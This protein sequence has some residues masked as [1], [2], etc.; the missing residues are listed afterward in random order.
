MDAVNGAPG[1]NP[2]WERSVTAQ[3]RV[4]HAKKK[5]SG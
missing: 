2:L 4:E 3:F 5:A 1:G